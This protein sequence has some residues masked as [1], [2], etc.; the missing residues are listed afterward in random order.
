[1]AR[2][3]RIEY[4][5]ALYH[6]IQRG[7]NRE[8]VFERSEDKYCLI[9]YFRKAVEL[10]DIELFA[11]VVMSNHYHLALRTLSVPLNRVMHRINTKYGMY[12]N[13]AMGRSGH[14]FEGRYKAF[15]VQDDRYLISLVKYIHRNPVKAGLCSSVRDYLWS[16][17]HFYRQMEHGFV[18]FG[19][20]FEMLSGDRERFMKEYDILMSQD[21]DTD[22]EAIINEAIINKVDFK[23]KMPDEDKNLIIERETL[24]EILK[25]A[26]NDKEEY[27]SI[28][29][30]SRMRRLTNAKLIYAIA[31]YEQGYSMQEIARHINVSATAVFKYINKASII[32]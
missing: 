13:K 23:P 21:D 5:G 7:F 2:K 29:K 14:I 25:K 31:A 16:S 27:E 9:E 11:Y 28:K 17:D 19:L 32:S 4:P 3:L 18:N 26:A 12:Y 20:L 22:C 15:L 1:L 30:G 24:D 8:N 6:V 10:D